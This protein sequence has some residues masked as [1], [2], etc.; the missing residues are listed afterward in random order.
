MRN[1]IK[2]ANKSVLD[3]A[4]CDDPIVKIEEKA[5]STVHEAMD[6]GW[7][8]PPFDPLKL[9]MLMN[10]QVR[11][12]ASIP[13]ARIKLVNDV[14]VIEFN[15]NKSVGR[16]NFSIA[17]EIAH[18]FFEDWNERT[19][20]RLCGGGDS[21]NW[22]LEM[23]CNIGAAEIL[24]PPGAFENYKYKNVSISEAL[25]LSRKF[26]VSMEALL[27]RLAKISTSPLMAF[28]ASRLQGNESPK[29]RIDY[30][31]PSANWEKDKLDGLI[32]NKSETLVQCV[33]I[34]STA[35]GKEKDFYHD[36]TVE[37]QAIGLPPYPYSDEM[38][39]AGIIRPSNN[40]NSCKN[41]QIEFRFGDASNPIFNKNVAIVH[42]VNDR[43]RN[44]SGRGFT[45]S[46]Y[47]SFPDAAKDYSVWTT[48]SNKFR[49]GEIHTY[50][51]SSDQ[52]VVSVIAQR[53]YGPS[54]TPRIRYSS[55][56]LGLEKTS[57]FLKN[58]G[59]DT[60]QM[61]RIGSGQAGGDWTIIEGMIYEYLVVRGIN[62]KVLDL[63]K[64]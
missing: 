64:R 32:L 6:K 40:L 38:R 4:Q 45:H 31:I 35:T 24:M 20:N 8:G 48:K 22:Q 42:I 13:D 36:S 33:A 3:F 5:Q 16:V 18:T 9:A 61:P 58:T 29:Y 10:F 26:N 11:P 19:R 27:I 57:S 1:P 63:P 15:P 51:N 59:I 60:V 43:A 56:H 7:S 47:R 54:S 44:W 55:L 30:S 17:H 28:A 12:N 14:K 23:L 62:V 25:V 49:L 34:G 50:L 37:V 41:P 39:Y 21:H 52:A 46:L 53:G 2:W